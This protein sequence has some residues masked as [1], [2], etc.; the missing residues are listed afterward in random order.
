M[1]A[2]QKLISTTSKVVKA[3]PWLL[4]NAVLTEVVIGLAVLP[5]SLTSSA[6]DILCVCA[7]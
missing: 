3:L 7:V 1:T 6:E 5:E 2:A 4:S